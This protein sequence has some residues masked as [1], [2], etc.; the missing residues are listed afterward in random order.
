MK[1]PGAVRIDPQ[2]ENDLLQALTIGAWCNN[3]QVVPGSGGDDWQV[4]GD[5]TEGALLVAAFK[6]GIEKRRHNRGVVYEIPFDSERKMMSVVVRESNESIMYSKGAP[7]VIL[8]RCKS[9]Q[10]AT[11][12]FS[13]S[14]R[15][16]P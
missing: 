13:R 10:F 3:A 16:V 7:E 5:P 6:A 8:D 15:S 2:R 12:L 4:V 11:V 1:Q 9:E 14:R